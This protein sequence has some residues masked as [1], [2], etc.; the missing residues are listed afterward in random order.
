MSNATIKNPVANPL[1][2]TTFDLTITDNVHGCVDTSQVVI[3]VLPREVSFTQDTTSGGIPLTVNFA[4]TSSPNLVSYHWD[5]GDGK[6]FDDVTNSSPTHVFETPG[7]Y[8]VVLSGVNAIGCSN[9]ASVEINA[10]LSDLTIPNVFTPNNDTKNDVFKVA[11]PGIV[12]FNGVIFN[13]WGKKEFEWT[14]PNNGWDGKGAP[15]GVY[16][17][18]IKAEGVDGQKFAKNGNITLAR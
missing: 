8:I 2:T 11:A 13:R 6:T 15:E 17:Y 16:Y 7:T 5:F 10:L 1:V 14:D 9:T 3:T 18:V 12:S 4:N